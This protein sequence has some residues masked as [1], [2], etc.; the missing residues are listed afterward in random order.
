[1]MVMVF[2]EPRLMDSHIH[3]SATGLMFSGL[4]LHPAV[5][6]AHYIQIV[7]DITRSPILE[8]TG[9]GARVGRIGVA[10]SHCAEH[11]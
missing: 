10:Q 2:V 3:L 8:P 11:Q 4:D 5:S 6:C 1:M 7:T 9:V